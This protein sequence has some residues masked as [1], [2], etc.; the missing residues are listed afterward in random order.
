MTYG[1]LGVHRGTPA[2]AAAVVSLVIKRGSCNPSHLSC[3]G[4]Q[5]MTGWTLTVCVLRVVRCHPGCGG[6]A[7]NQPEGVF[8][9]DRAEALACAVQRVV[10]AF[11]PPMGSADLV[12]DAG[13]TG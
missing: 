5:C 3:M 11:A 7:V 8:D 9:A 4:F 12:D 1:C 10:A 6:L 2:Q 13:A